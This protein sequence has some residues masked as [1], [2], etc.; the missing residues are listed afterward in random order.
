M[1]VRSSAA[2]RDKWTARA[3]S[4]ALAAATAS[5]SESA[6]T[7][8]RAGRSAPGTSQPRARS[9]RSGGG[10]S[11]LP[12]SPEERDLPPASAAAA[13]REPSLL[14]PFVPRRARHTTKLAR[15]AVPR[16]RWH[17]PSAPLERFSASESHTNSPIYQDRF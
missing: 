6:T 17:C 14:Q 12:A 11:P 2:K 9:S 3:L 7:S 4:P 5:S 10:L 13:R 15:K 1:R 16:L 8:A